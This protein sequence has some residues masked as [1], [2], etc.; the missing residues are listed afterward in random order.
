MSENDKDVERAQEML[1]PEDFDGGLHNVEPP[2]SFYE[3]SAKDAA[4]AAEFIIINDG[5]DDIPYKVDGVNVTFTPEELM[6][7][8]EVLE[9]YSINMRTLDYAY[10]EMK[11]ES[12]YDQQAL[13]R[14]LRDNVSGTLDHYVRVR[15]F[16]P[17]LLPWLKRINKD[18]VRKGD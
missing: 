4:E 9:N 17:F 5:A 2:Q 6:I 18:R 1:T 12:T 7:L 10:D 13:V 3:Q 14:Q 8:T 15:P 11:I 16:T